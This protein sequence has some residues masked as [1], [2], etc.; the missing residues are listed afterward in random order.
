MSYSWKPV[1]IWVRWVILFLCLPI[2]ILL[3]CYIFF[4]GFLYWLFY[5]RDK[6]KK[7]MLQFVENMDKI[8]FMNPRPDILHT[9][10][11]AKRMGYKTAIYNSTIPQRKSIFKKKSFDLFIEKESA[12]F[13][14]IIKADCTGDIIQFAKQNDVD[15]F[16]SIFIKSLQNELKDLDM[17]SSLQLLDSGR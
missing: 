5:D 8:N 9:L 4:K 17:F 10:Y 11:K 3:F 2:I 7:V 12:R 1:P 14:Y 15:L 13:D 6:S 16:Q